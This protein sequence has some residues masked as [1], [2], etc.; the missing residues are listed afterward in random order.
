MIPLFIEEI[1]EGCFFQCRAVSR[2]V[3]EVGIQIKRIGKGAFSCCFVRSIRLPASLETLENYVLGADS[4]VEVSFEPDSNLREISDSGFV[5]LRNKI[6]IIEFPRKCQISSGRPLEDLKY[7]IFAKENGFHFTENDVFYD[8]DKRTLIRYLG[9]DSEICVR[10]FVKNIGPRCFLGKEGLRE[11]RFEAGC[12]VTNFEVFT[13]L[14]SGVRSILIPSRIQTIGSCCF[15]CSSL[16]EIAFE[17]GCQVTEFG[18]GA[19]CNCALRSIVIPSCVKTIGD[20]CFFECQKLSEVTF[21]AD[22][23]ITD[24]GAEVFSQC[25]I[26]SIIIPSSVRMMGTKCFSPI[27]PLRGVTFDSNCKI[28]A[29]GMCFCESR[30]LCEVVFNAPCNIVS[31]SER[32]FYQCPI[33]K[34]TIPSS[35]RE[36]GKECFRE[37][38]KL[39]EVMFEPGSELSEIGDSAFCQSGLQSI[40]IPS[41]LQRISE[42]CFQ[43]CESLHEVTFENNCRISVFE[44]YA[45]AG[46]GLVSIKI[47]VCVKRIGKFCFLGCKNLCDVSFESNCELTVIEESA[48]SD[49]G[50]K[51]ITIPDSVEGIG[52][53]CFHGCQNLA[54]I[55]F[56]PNS[57]VGKRKQLFI[58]SEMWSR[59]LTAGECSD[60]D[61][62][63]DALL[64]KAVYF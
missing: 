47:P 29:L 56:A 52:Q 6:E 44:A 3:F 14:S 43:G 31:I 55:A 49:C 36:I 39:I 60:F 30:Q 42:N 37:C 51:S 59:S 17:G 54:E 57:K 63:C 21:E 12:E 50:M 16:S 45:F 19:F 24:I 8:K 7:C 13:F 23:N 18:P 4:L 15:R 35:V 41:H 34:I 61:T 53:K 62:R 10:K 46:T 2:I 20:R 40:R 28:T 1:E 5:S 32:T 11:V 9:T 58:L 26:E 33:T 64:R 38:K 22:S 48:F 27:W 25:K